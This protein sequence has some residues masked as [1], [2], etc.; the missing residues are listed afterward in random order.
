[1]RERERERKEGKMQLKGGSE[2]SVSWQISHS[3]S[4]QQTYHIII[5][6]SLWTCCLNQEDVRML[7]YKQHYLQYCY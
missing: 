1:M 2:G 7:S 4:I 3:Q 6:M 5:A